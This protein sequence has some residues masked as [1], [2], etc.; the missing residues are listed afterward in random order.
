MAT[1][2]EVSEKLGHGGG[3][4]RHNIWPLALVVLGKF[5]PARG[6]Y[7]CNAVGPCLSKGGRGLTVGSRDVILYGRVYDPLPLTCD[8]RLRE[9]RHLMHQRCTA[10][11]GVHRNNH[12]MST[13]RE[14]TLLCC[15][16]TL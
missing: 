13:P 1:K 2:E 7:S 12:T 10:D 15:S 5:F 3:V 16:P 9:K 6:S 4:C 14:D 8:E 11:L